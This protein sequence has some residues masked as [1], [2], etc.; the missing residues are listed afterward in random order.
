MT[1]WVFIVY[2]CL[3]FPALLQWMDHILTTDQVQ[4]ANKGDWFTG[5]STL[6]LIKKSLNGKRGYTTK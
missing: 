2:E 3:H 6:E 5:G 4:D 1:F